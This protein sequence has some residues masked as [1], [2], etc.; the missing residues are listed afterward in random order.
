MKNAALS[1]RHEE[2]RALLAGR[3]EV[4]VAEMARHFKVTPMTIR[5]DLDAMSRAGV[6]N[7]T[8]GGALLAAPAVAAFEFLD[9]R[10]S[11]PSEKQAVARAAAALVR[12]GM[13]LLLDTGT[14]TLELAKLLGGI[15]K[16][17][18]VTSSLAIASVLFA[19]PDVELVML[20]GTV[21]RHSPDLSGPLTVENLRMFKADTAF[22]GADAA[23]RD[24]IYTSSMAIA[25]VS[26]AIISGARRAVLLAD[27]SKFKADA[28]IRICEW[29]SLN[30]AVVDRGLAAENRKWLEK[31]VP[32]LIIAD[33]DVTNRN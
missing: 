24:G 13:T 18:V 12:P 1:P 21:G 7:R 16:L 27:S 29:N 20:G 9:R 6:I 14:T 26:K 30:T 23:G 2:I 31:A 10:S 3:R 8:H 5:R 33:T 32:D 4:S 19:S 17:T 25:Q 22:V 28:A 15:P 11:R